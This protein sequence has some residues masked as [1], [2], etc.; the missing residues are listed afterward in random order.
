V[1]ILEASLRSIE[2]ALKAFA[3]KRPDNDEFIPMESVA[4]LWASVLATRSAWRTMN[5]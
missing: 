2:G 3:L 1:E 4:A 5:L